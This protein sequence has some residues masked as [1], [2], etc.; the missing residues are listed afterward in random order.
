MTNVTTKAI[1][2]THMSLYPSKD[3]LIEAVQF[4][5]A[6]APIE[7]HEVFPLLMLYHN[8][9]IAELARSGESNVVPLKRPSSKR[10]AP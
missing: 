4:I 7:P 5:E 8:S 1:Q 2:A 10:Q 9:L 3:S 6:Q